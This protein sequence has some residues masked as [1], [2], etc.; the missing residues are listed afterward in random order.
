MSFN[1]ANLFLQT[2]YNTVSAGYPGLFGYFSTE[3]DIA[4]I[5]TDGYFPFDILTG[6]AG[7]T[8]CIIVSATDGGVLRAFDSNFNLI[9]PTT[10]SSNIS[11]IT[12]SSASLYANNYYLINNFANGTYTLPDATT[13]KGQFVNLKKISD[14]FT[15]TINTVNSQDIDGSSSLLITVLNDSATLISDGS[16]WWTY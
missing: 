7:A 16:N 10:L 5:L 15:A 14:L 2:P 12:S 4:T 6:W 9:N 8:D 13:C 1:A 11:T 3:D